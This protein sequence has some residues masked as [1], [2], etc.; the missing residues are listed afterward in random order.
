MGQAPGHPLTFFDY[1]SKTECHIM[2]TRPTYY[3]IFLFGFIFILVFVS[4][5][6]KDQPPPSSATNFQYFSLI[7][8][9]DKTVL[10]DSKHRI[11]VRVPDNIISGTQL[12]ANYTISPGASLTQGGITQQCGITINDFEKDLTYTLIAADQHTRVAWT[13]QATNNDYSISWGMGHFI[14]RSLSEDRSY[15]WYIDQSTSG[16]FALVNCGPASVTMAIRW[17]DSSF[18][19]TALDARLTY[20]TGGGWWYTS[21]INTYLNNYNISHAI[22]GLSDNADT[23]MTILTHQLDNHQIIILCLDMNYVR[24]SVDPAFR[25]DKFYLTSPG[26]GHFIVLKGYQKVDEEVFFEVY[27]PYS[28]GLVNPDQTLKGMN[29]FY[30]Y[31]DLAAA[32][33]HWWNYA[34]VIAKKEENLSLDAVKRKLNPALVPVAHNF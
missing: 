34:F 19:K 15:N 31:E 6:K 30:R 33:Q 18:S 9:K 7:P 14:N 11:S 27:D 29:R 25:A 10:D 3:T 17:A 2:F 32:C 4:C 16:E 21:D 23:S 13:V 28:F 8:G 5:S 26:W 24:S 20:E 22:I 1:F 12:I